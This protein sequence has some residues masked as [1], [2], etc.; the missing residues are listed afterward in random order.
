MTPPQTGDS[1]TSKKTT[2]HVCE[3]LW[4]FVTPLTRG[5]VVHALLTAVLRCEV[6]RRSDF[7]SFSSF[8]QD[9]EA[10]ENVFVFLRRGLWWQG[11]E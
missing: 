9:Y 1:V 10:G 8:A 5:A 4:L 11:R 2:K 7:R 3:L 6:Q